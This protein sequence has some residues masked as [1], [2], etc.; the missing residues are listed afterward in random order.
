[1]L[2]REAQRRIDYHESR[3]KLWTLYPETG[4]LRREAY[5]RHMEFFAA[6]SFHMQRAFIA[7]N[8]TG[9]TTA[10]A[11]ELTLHATGRYPA[12]WTG[13]R[14]ERPISAWAAGVDVKA[15]RESVQE[16]LLGVPKFPLGTGVMPGDDIIDT[17]AQ[18]GGGD[19]IESV[20]VKHQGGGRSRILF[21]TYEQGRESFQGSKL[22]VGW[23]DEEPPLDIYNEFLT[24]LMSTVPGEPNGA[25]MCTF[26]PLK[27]MSEVARRYLGD[28]WT[29]PAPVESG[30]D[31]R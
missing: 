29:P 28:D 23:C 22:D 5:P 20:V 1:M 31:W 30:S 14:F 17:T 16:I 7:A 3:R 25:M 13:R 26:T 18:R 19:A 10:A 15:L 9:K 6:G 2:A 8:R 4:P 12:W 21:K 11:Y 27:G 24:R